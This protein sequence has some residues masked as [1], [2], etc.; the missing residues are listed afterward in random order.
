MKYIET[1][2]EGEKVGDIY[3]CKSKSSAVTKNGQD[4][5]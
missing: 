1:F 2:R 5:T 3:F 4:K